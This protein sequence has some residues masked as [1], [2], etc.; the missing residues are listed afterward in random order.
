MTDSEILAQLD[1]AVGASSVAR[2]VEN[3]LTALERQLDD[4]PTA[5]MSWEPIPLELYGPLPPEIRSSWIFVL[6]EGTTTGAER[7]PNSHQRMMS[8]RGSADFPEIH[9]GEWRSHPLTSDRSA[10]IPERWATI[11]PYTWHQ[12]IVPS[13]EHW[14]VV[15]FHTVLAAELIEERPTADGVEGKP[16]LGAG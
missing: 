4:D 1:A 12:A 8:Y 7:H 15:S 13:G 11:P 14:V 2:H 5:I 10:P 3:R 16:Y 6:R 9:D